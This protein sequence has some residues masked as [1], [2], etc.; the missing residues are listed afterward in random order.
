MTRAEAAKLL[1][2]LRAGFPRAFAQID[3]EQADMMISVWAEMLED[4]TYPQVNAAVRALFQTNTFMPSIAEIRQTVV[5]M[6]RGPVR[7]G[8]EG[9]RDF[10]DAVSRFGFYRDPEF[11]DPLVARCVDALGWQTLCSSE[12]QV[13]DR[14]RFID[15]YDALAASQRDEH[16]SPVLAE[17]RKARE[18]TEAEALVRQVS[19]ILSKK[20]PDDPPE[21]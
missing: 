3:A 17:A 8:A 11:N 15:L 16:V 6:Q 9:W 4:L 7:Q 2:V 10:L 13:S 1:S 18:L 12:N 21:A 5:K 20:G 14:A 19:E